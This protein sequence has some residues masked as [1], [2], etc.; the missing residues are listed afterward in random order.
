MEA[1]AV[2]KLFYHPSRKNKLLI[3]KLDDSRKLFT[4][5]EWIFDSCHG[6]AFISFSNQL[7]VYLEKYVN[8][9]KLFLVKDV[10]VNR[11]YYSVL[12]FRVWNHIFLCERLNHFSD[13]CRYCSKLCIK[14][15]KNIRP[16]Q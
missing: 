14:N 8:E 4:C 5:D 6:D 1:S 3:K 13:M 16:Y 10:L 11:L 9:Q 15:K 7:F 12:H 2:C